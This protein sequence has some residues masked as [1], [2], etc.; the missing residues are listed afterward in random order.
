MLKKLQ[1]KFILILMSFVSVILLSVFGVV[2]CSNYVHDKK[3]VE[4]SLEMA[5]KLKDKD[6]NISFGKIKIKIKQ[7]APTSIDRNINLRSF[8]LNSSYFLFAYAFVMFG[9]SADAIDMEKKL[10]MDKRGTMYELIIPY[11]IV[12]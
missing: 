10:G 8:R 4:R 6:F 5:L 11:S 9:S 12:M 1:T 7:I 3:D 2:C